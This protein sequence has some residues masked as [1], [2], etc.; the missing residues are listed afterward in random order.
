[1]QTPPDVPDFGNSELWVVRTT[2]RERYG[3]DI[4][5]EGV[6]VEVRLNPQ[7]RITTPCPGLFW[8][9]DDTRFI[10]IKTGERR[11]RCQFWHR[12]YQQYG[13]GKHEYDDLT[14]CIVS[15]LQTQADHESERA[16]HYP[17]SA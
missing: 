11:Y 12:L 15:L 9:R 2:L 16:G 13:T 6:E 1:M 5:P 10:L 8:E 4:E 14:E 17:G 7:D 3:Q